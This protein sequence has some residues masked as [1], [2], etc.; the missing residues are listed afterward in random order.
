MPALN[1][2][3]PPD[4]SS[5]QRGL[6]SIAAQSFEGVK[7]FA[8]RIVASL[9]VSAGAA[10]LELSSDLGGGSSD[11]ATKLGTTVANASVSATAKLA[12]FRT[13]IGGT[14]VEKLAV[15]STGQLIGDGGWTK[16]PKIP[17]KSHSH[18]ILKLNHNKTKIRLYLFIRSRS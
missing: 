5:T 8:K 18:N 14:E 9:G 10:M 13:G 4:A 1:N 6:V 11:L 2:S 12:T 15:L 16:T 17:N 7:T 3:P